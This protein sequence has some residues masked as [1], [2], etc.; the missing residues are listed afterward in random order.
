[1][2]GKAREAYAREPPLTAL[3]QGAGGVNYPA[4]G[5]AAAQVAHASGI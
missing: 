3:S 4:F 5:R 1:M 2:R